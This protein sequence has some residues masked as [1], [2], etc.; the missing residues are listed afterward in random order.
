MSPSLVAFDN[1]NKNINHN[2]RFNFYLSHTHMYNYHVI[3]SMHDDGIV[4]VISCILKI[5]FRI[6]KKKNNDHRNESLIDFAWTEF[7]R[8]K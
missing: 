7:A 6:M 2:N 5:R 4:I 1:T 3:I 8:T